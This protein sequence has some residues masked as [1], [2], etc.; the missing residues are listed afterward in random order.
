MALDRFDDSFGMVRI[1]KAVAI[2]DCRNRL[3][4]IKTERVGFQL[5]ELR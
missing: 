2:I 3:K 5:G 4:G 1:E